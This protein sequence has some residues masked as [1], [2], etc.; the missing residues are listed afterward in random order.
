MTAFKRAVV[1]VS[2]NVLCVA[3][4]G[5]WVLFGDKLKEVNAQV[6]QYER[7]IFLLLPFLATMLLRGSGC[8]GDELIFC[9]TPVL[10]SWLCYRTLNIA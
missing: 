1:R 6:G 2:T 4:E 8:S 3:H 10:K 9:S 7:C 5:G